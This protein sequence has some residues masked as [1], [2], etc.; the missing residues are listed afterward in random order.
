ML[1]LAAGLP[2]IP[3]LAKSVFVG[4]LKHDIVYPG[5]LVLYRIIALEQPADPN[6]RIPQIGV[7]AVALFFPIGRSIPL[8]ARKATAI[9]GNA[10]E[11]IVIADLNLPLQPE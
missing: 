11:D 10:K 2:A 6:T 5:A 4:R 7:Q 9:T 3:E 8:V 1:V